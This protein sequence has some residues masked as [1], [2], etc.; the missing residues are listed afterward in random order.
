MHAAH[1]LV[2]GRKMSKSMNNE[3][4]LEDLAARGF[5]P[6]DFRYYCLTF[7]Y[8]T[9][10]NFTWE[11]QAAAAK[12]FSRLKK[13]VS[14]AAASAE[15]DGAEQASVFRQ[16]F[17]ECLEDDLNISKAV[18]VVHEAAHAGLPSE[19][20]RELAVEWDDVLGL[21]IASAAEDEKLPSNVVE[22]VARRDAARKARNFAEA[23]ALREQIKDAGY[24]VMDA[25]GTGTRIK[26]IR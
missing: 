3:Y 10:M 2:D 15:G 4:T 12:A 8:R 16:R 6:M 5:D 13:A 18:G 21:G 22:L 1:L 25:G 11:G 14:G 20:L 19:T 24:E 7:H 23:D 26:K 17:R 9:P